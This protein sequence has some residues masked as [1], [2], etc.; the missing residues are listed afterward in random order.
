MR[1]GMMIV[2]GVLCV[3]LSLAAAQ[4]GTAAKLVGTWEIITKGGLPPGSTLTFSK[5]G[6]LLLMFDHDGK[7]TKAEGTY[8][9]KDNTISSK[10]SF[11][12][13][14]IVKESIEVHK[15]KKLTDA[16]LHTE[17]KN[18]KIDEFKKK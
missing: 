12:D 5:D 3:A 11:N 6:K 17:D 16:E 2:T 9:V 14:G 10:M 4:E 15:I 1:R 8:A 18:G 7:T 13:M